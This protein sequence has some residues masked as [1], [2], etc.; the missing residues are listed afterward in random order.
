MPVLFV[1][2]GLLAAVA[3]VFL[4]AAWPNG[5]R[6]SWFVI[7]LVALAGHGRAGLTWYFLAAAALAADLA[8][9]DGLWGARFIGYAL[10]YWL[11]R[12][13][14]TRSLPLNRRWAAGLLTFSLTLIYKAG[15]VS[16][17]YFLS[18]WGGASELWPRDW[19]LAATAES[20]LSAGLLLLAVFLARRA[21]VLTRRWFLIR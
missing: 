11:G 1:G 19:F 6:V 5:T 21:R 4:T 3:D 17:V 9:D 10:L 2:L 12:S 18:W 13:L 16:Y 14:M 7:G 8:L 20:A 15:G